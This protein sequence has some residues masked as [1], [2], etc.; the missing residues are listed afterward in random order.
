MKAAGRTI[1]AGELI[2]HLSGLGQNTHIWLDVYGDWEPIEELSGP[3]IFGP[4][5][6]HPYQSAHELLMELQEFTGTK[7]ALV[8]M[9]QSYSY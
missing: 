8:E 3:L 6:D 1:T 2:E 7:K 9:I 5:D 4:E